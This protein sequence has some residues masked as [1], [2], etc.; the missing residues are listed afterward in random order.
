M[1]EFLKGRTVMGSGRAANISCEAVQ[2]CHL[3]VFL[4][5][6]PPEDRVFEATVI[7]HTLICPAC[8]EYLDRLV[9]DKMVDQTQ[10]DGEPG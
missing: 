10:Q 1:D 3:Q 6:E 7:A 4:S 9:N 5:G 2:A 8:G